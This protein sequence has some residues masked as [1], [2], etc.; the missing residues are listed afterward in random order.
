LLNFVPFTKEMGKSL[1]F[2]FI[3][4]CSIDHGMINTCNT[5][6]VGTTIH[7]PFLLKELHSFLLLFHHLLLLLDIWNLISALLRGHKWVW[8]LA[9]FELCRL[10]GSLSEFKIFFVMCL[11]DIPLNVTVRHEGID[12]ILDLFIWIV[13]KDIMNVFF[14]SF[15]GESGS[16]LK[17]ETL[18]RDQLFGTG[19]FRGPGWGSLRELSLNSLGDH[20][21]STPFCSVE[22]LVEM[23]SVPGIGDSFM[24]GNHFE[25]FMGGWGCDWASVFKWSVEISLLV[26]FSKV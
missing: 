23:P 6:R 16:S 20:G 8:L 17:E 14:L 9:E 2:F 13:L 4:I 26:T 10:K 22:E 1:I 24:V 11:C 7:S 5:L 25:F 15:G 21:W 18:L 19:G 3:D 12:F